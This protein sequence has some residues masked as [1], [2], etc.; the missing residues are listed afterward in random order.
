MKKLGARRARLKWHT[1]ANSRQHR[2]CGG[3]LLDGSHHPG[4]SLVAWRIVRTCRCSSGTVGR[5]WSDLRI[6]R[7]QRR[8]RK[9]W[10]WLHK[11]TAHGSKRISRHACLIVGFLLVV[12]GVIDVVTVT[13][14]ALILIV[15]V[16]VV[17]VDQVDVI[18]HGRVGIGGGV[19]RG[20]AVLRSGRQGAKP[21]LDQLQGRETFGTGRETNACD[22]G[23]ATVQSGNGQER[24]VDHRRSGL[25]EGRR[26]RVSV[27]LTSATLRLETD[28]GRAS[29]AAVQRRGKPLDQRVQKAQQRDVLVVC[30]AVTAAA[31]GHR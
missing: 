6:R 17:V 24:T 31:L 11:E 22:L 14:A 27:L 8:H 21:L 2:C 9:R 1:P 13:N 10:R 7:R 20:C 18:L 29:A 19:G 30:G 28:T 4:Q 3:R 25:G 5:R 15:V 26:E 12:I 23:T 16:V